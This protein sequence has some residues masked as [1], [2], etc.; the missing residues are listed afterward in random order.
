MIQKEL[1]AWSMSVAD[2]LQS[3]QSRKTG[4][5]RQDAI[6]RYDVKKTNEIDA[7]SQVPAWKIF[8]GQFKS[9]L[10]L[11]LIGASVLSFIL[12]E[13]TDTA[14]ILLMVFLGAILAFLQEY[15][16]ERALRQLRIKL[17]RRAKVIRDGKSIDIDAKEVVVGDI[18]ELK[19]GTVVSAD[20]R[21]ISVNDLEVDESSLT[22]ESVPVT[23]IIEIV[24]GQKLAPQDKVN[25][26]FLGTHVVQGSGMG[27]VIDIG[28]NTEMGKTA[29][30]LSKKTDETNFQAGIREFGNFILKTTIALCFFVGITLGFIHGDWAKSILFALALAVGISPELLPVI[31]TMNLS[32]GAFRMSKKYVLVKRLISIEDLGSADVLCTDK[33]GTLTIG[34][35]R[36]RDSIGPDGISNPRILEYASQCIDVGSDGRATNPVDQALQDAGTKTQVHVYEKIAFDFLRRRM[37]CVVQDASGGRRMIVKG[38]TQE[39]ISQCID[40]DH[41]KLNAFADTYHDKGYRLVAVA[42]R[43]IE[44]KRSYTSDD[45][46]NL[47]LLGFI[48]VSDAP[49]E[50]AKT[51]LCQLEKLQVRVIILTGD[52]ERVTA[53]VAEQLD[54]KI[55]GLMTGIQID[56]MN[57]TEL[58]HAVEQN[59]IFAKITPT[60]KLRIIQTLKRLKHAVAFMGDG[61]NDAPALREADAGI[62]FQEAVDVAKEAAGIILL[63]RNLSVLADGILE[64]RRTFVKTRTYIHATISSNF[65]NML[66]VAGAALFLPFIPL[67]PAQI[68]LLNI[69]SDIPMLCIP[70]DNVPNDEIK[71]PLKWNIGE[72]KHFMYFFG[73]ISSAADYVMFGTLL[74]IFKAGPELFQSGW[75][76]GSMLTEVIVI[77]ILRTNRFSMKN[78]PSKPLII[79]SVTMAIVT[80][81]ITQSPLGKTLNLIPLQPM[82]LLS[83]I[84]IV[85]GYAGI[86][87]LGKIIYRRTLV[88]SPIT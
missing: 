68:L 81:V 79:A 36:V 28:H 78:S 48:L 7:D 16:S 54:F 2:V 51:A 76:I 30:L 43:A 64:G 39:V 72:I 20:M 15:R 21:L 82:V 55:H 45:E 47:T 60:H 52:N 27:V 83:I 37:S 53:F 25:C 87:E 32:H 84:C 1:Q 40:C 3:V 73:M 85:I 11:I 62:S 88:P 26:V 6:S 34:T 80:L 58:E 63:K 12:G 42:T 46:K 19:L 13:K 4:L 22:G 14:L 75:F 38:A 23:K 67:L 8:L 49:K 35:L 18:V 24:P 9:S 86:T 69:L 5:S 10:T 59:N 44:E 65:G 50:T 41:E 17:S 57:D 71:K 77:F 33:T 66:S 29:S 56:S 31:V 70:T 74:L 61:V